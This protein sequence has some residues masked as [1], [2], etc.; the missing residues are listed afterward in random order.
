MNDD[1]E[2]YD[3]ENEFKKLIFYWH[4]PPYPTKVQKFL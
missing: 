4:S 1:D 3:E 2:E